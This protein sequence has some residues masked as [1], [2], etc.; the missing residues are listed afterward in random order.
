MQ[1]KRNMLS[2]PMPVAH[3]IVACP[4]RSQIFG[5]CIILF[6]M[7]LHMSAPAVVWAKPQAPG[8]ALSP[9]ME[10]KAN[11]VCARTD[12]FNCYSNNKYG[13]QVAWPHKLLTAQGESDAGDGQIFSAP[14]G[15]A[16]LT[17]W[18]GFT[19]VLPQSLQKGFEEA[20]QE[21]GLQV[22][23]KHKGKNFFVVSG[24][25]EGM[26]VYRK[27]VI[28]SQVQAT[29]VLTYSQAQKNEFDPI[30]GDIANSLI[31]YGH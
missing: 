12:I 17:C 22:T 20:Q 10:T 24:N 31:I 9:E 7:L 5:I 18:A 2:L 25:K 15:P 26:I 19:N 27:T 11:A 30:V 6:I 23:Y 8:G 16:Q 3:R 21:P 1:A 29:F 28:T 13:Y 4:A 14:D